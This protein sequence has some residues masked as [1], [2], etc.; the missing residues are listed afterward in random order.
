[1]EVFHAYRQTDAA[2]LVGSLQG[3]TIFVPNFRIYQDISPSDYLAIL[4]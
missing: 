4:N 1:M 3:R 2:I